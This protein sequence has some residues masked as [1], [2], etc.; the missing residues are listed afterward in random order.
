MT[1]KKGDRVRVKVGPYAGEFATFRG[2][3]PPDDGS[4]KDRAVILERDK[5]THRLRW[6]ALDELEL[7]KPSMSFAA[8]VGLA[9]AA[10]LG[11]GGLAALLTRKGSQ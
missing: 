6:Y 2:T 7:V 8:K 11:V 9:V 10:V 5:G 4:N 3:W 1:M